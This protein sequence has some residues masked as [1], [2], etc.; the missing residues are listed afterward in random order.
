MHNSI[1]KATMPNIKGTHGG[2]MTRYGPGTVSRT[3]SKNRL[4]LAEPARR[5]RF[6]HAP[7]CLVKP[8]SCDAGK[9]LESNGSVRLTEVLCD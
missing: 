3:R 1:H 4:N 8:C 9:V 6:S 5:C 2:S 7:K